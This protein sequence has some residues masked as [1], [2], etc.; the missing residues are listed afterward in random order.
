MFSWLKKYFSKPYVLPKAE[1]QD[2]VLVEATNYVKCQRC[3]SM[4]SKKYGDAPLCLRPPVLRRARRYSAVRD[5]LPP[6]T[7]EST[8]P[9]YS[10]PTSQVSVP[11]VSVPEVSIPVFRSGSGG[12][13]F[14]GG[15]AS[16]SWGAEDALPPMATNVVAFTRAAPAPIPF[17]APDDPLSTAG[18]G[19]PT[20]REATPPLE[21]SAP[22]SSYEA[23]APAPS[24]AYE[25]PAPSPAYASSYDSSSSSSSDFSSS[26]S[27][28]SSSSD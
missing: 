21:S 9:Y 15:G 22:I 16:S 28:G 14:A 5:E 13:D 1:H 12:G 7:P 18:L 2:C 25:A 19:V 23:P 11:E 24:P 27:S 4:T 6:R 17:Y 3:G 10:P 20:A 26:F 8:W